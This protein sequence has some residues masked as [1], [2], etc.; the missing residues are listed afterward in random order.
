MEGVEEDV[1]GGGAGDLHQVLHLRHHGDLPSVRG[2]HRVDGAG[3]LRAGP[4]GAPAVRERDPP[5]HGQRPGDPVRAGL[6]GGAAPHARH[7]PAALMAGAVLHIPIPHPSLPTGV[8]AAEDLRPGRGHCG[9]RWGDRGVVRARH[10][11]VYCVVHVPDVPAGAEQEH[12]HCIPGRG[13]AR[14]ACVSLVA[15]DR[16][17]W[18]GF[19]W[20][21][22]R[23]LWPVVKLSLSSGAMLC[24]ELWYNSILVLLTGNLKDAEVEIDAISIC[25]NINGWEMMISL[26]FLAAASVRV[27][28]EL[29]RGSKK[30]AK[31]SVVMVVLTSLS[32]GSVLFLCFLFLRGKLAYIFTENPAVVAAVTRLSPFLAISILFNSVQPV[33]SGVAVGAGWQSIV[34]YVNIACYY[35]VGIPLGVVLGYVLH[36]QVTG[37]W[38]GMLVGT[39]VQ[40]LVL[41]VI[42]WTTDWDKQV[43]MAQQRVRKWFLPETQRS[44]SHPELA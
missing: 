31:F 8:S 21:A 33:L 16:Q 14:A 27:S 23:D 3:G 43:I 6:R 10:F 25:L 15:A 7:I 2:A 26:G 41:I 37:I 9:G 34:A 40:T 11:R 20:M 12:D 5:G 36:F 1:G 19:S 30:A 39:A 13:L 35:I 44:N 28:N 17:T 29:G 4:D 22:F 32:I 38:I 18:N 24:L 42:T